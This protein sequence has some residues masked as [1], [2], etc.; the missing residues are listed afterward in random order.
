MNDQVETI[1]PDEPVITFASVDESDNVKQ[2]MK[3]F[4]E[5]NYNKKIREFQEFR[6]KLI[7]I[8]IGGILEKRKT[9]RKKHKEERTRR[10]QQ[11]KIRRQRCGK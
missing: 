1:K 8:K 3:A 11:R 10:C 7:N 5:Y 6:R 4:D 9:Q 2:S